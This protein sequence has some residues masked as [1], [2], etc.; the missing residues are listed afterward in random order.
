[1]SFSDRERLAFLKARFSLLARRL[2]LPFIHG[3]LRR[4][5]VILEGTKADTISCNRDDNWHH[6]SSTGVEVVLDVVK[7]VENWLRW[8]LMLGRSAFFH[9]KIFLRTGFRRL[10]EASDTVKTISWSLTPGNGIHLET[11]DGLLVRN[12]SKV[13]SSLV[14]KSAICVKPRSRKVDM[15]HSLMERRTGNGDLWLPH[16]TNQYLVN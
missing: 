5:V 14:G 3:W 6:R 4:V 1:M 12:K 9:R 10:A 13:L 11:K 15:K 2:T 7:L 8:S 16:L